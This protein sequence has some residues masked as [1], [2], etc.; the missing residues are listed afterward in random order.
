M[1]Y[2]Y[3]G[4]LGQVYNITVDI[5]DKCT[6]SW[7]ISIYNILVDID[8]QWIFITVCVNSTFNRVDVY[9]GKKDRSLY[10]HTLTKFLKSLACFVRSV[11]PKLIRDFTILHRRP[12]VQVG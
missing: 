3:G 2:Q 10:R 11:V 8:S 9:L 6:I 12:K 5:L 4:H 7:W 1:Q